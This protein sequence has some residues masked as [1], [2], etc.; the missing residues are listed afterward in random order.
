[1]FH[2]GYKL[3][4]VYSAVLGKWQQSD[5]S[6]VVSAFKL[7]S[8]IFQTAF[9]FYRDTGQRQRQHFKFYI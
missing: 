4:F 7:V 2:T 8:N 9:R 5:M 6:N 3:A 1:M